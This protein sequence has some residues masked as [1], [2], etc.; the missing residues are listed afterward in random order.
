MARVV[1][2][3]IYALL[4][5]GGSAYADIR[6]LQ[7]YLLG[8]YTTGVANYQA[9]QNDASF[10][11]D[12]S[13]MVDLM[14]VELRWREGIKGSKKWKFAGSLEVESIR[15]QVLGGTYYLPRVQ[16]RV[17]WGRNTLITERWRFAPVLQLNGGRYSLFD[18]TATHT[19]RQETVTR[20]STGIGLSL[21]HRRRFIVGPYIRDRFEFVV[22]GMLRYDFG[23]SPKI[24]NTDLMGSLTYQVEVG[25]TQAIGRRSFIDIRGRWID[26]MYRWRP[27]NSGTNSDNYFLNRMYLIDFGLGYKF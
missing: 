2:T 12:S 17:S 14:G 7:W 20:F 21:L 9:G 16:A 8:R 26:E 15:Q 6:N 22:L 24:L 18:V 11:G 23:L 1:Y 25:V 13:A 4:L 5:L 19:A 27:R 3:F 10:H